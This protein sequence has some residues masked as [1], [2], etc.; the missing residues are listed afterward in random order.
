MRHNFLSVQ[1]E[2]DCLHGETEAGMEKEG[3][4][5]LLVTKTGHI[6][7]HVPPHLDACSAES[8]CGLHVQCVADLSGGHQNVWYF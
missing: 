6:L 8:C 4:F 1:L 2:I 5:R 3:L 7:N